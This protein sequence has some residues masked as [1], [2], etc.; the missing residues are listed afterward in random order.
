ML[1]DLHAALRSYR[2]ELPMVVMRPP[3]RTKVGL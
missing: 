1:K 3:R 2:G